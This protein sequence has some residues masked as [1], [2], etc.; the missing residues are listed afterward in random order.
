ARRRLH[1]IVGGLCSAFHVRCSGNKFQLNRAEL[2]NLLGGELSHYLEASR[3][4]R[5][6]QE[7]ISDLDKN[8]D[9]T[10]DFEEFVAMVTQLTN[11]D[12]SVNSKKK[13]SVS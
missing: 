6:V 3:D 1:C 4:P 2:R 9:G 10:M 5:R 13:Y 12:F 7:I 11:S 8:L